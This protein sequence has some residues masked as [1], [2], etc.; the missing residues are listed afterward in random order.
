MRLYYAQSLFAVDSASG[1]LSQF[2][3]YVVHENLI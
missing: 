1:Q 3:L 2:I